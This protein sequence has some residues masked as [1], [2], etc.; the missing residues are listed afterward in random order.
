MHE[1]FSKGD[2]TSIVSAQTDILVLIILKTEHEIFNITV[3]VFACDR[4]KAYEM[5]QR[6]NALI[7]VVI[8]GDH[9]NTKKTRCTYRYMSVLPWKDTIFTLK[10]YEKHVLII[11]ITFTEASTHTV[12]IYFLVT[13][14]TPLG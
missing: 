9:F 6:M 2:H 11:L 7:H 10:L 13:D 3:F 5:L 12:K 1:T 8:P 14:L 4:N